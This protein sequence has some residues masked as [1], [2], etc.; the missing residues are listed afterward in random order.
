MKKLILIS[1]ISTIIA[2]SASSQSKQGWTNTE[3]V[4]FY[5]GLL[6]SDSSTKRSVYSVEFLKF[7]VSL[8]RAS[9]YQK[10]GVGTALAEVNVVGNYKP[11]GTILPLY[12]QFIPWMKIRSYAYQPIKSSSKDS[13]GN[14]TLTYDPTKTS[15]EDGAKAFIAITLVG[16]LWGLGE[17]KTLSDGS[18]VRQWNVKYF[19]GRIA[20]IKN[21]RIKSKGTMG[22]SNGF[23]FNVSAEINNYIFF[24]NKEVRY[25]PNIGVRLF[26]GSIL[27][28]Y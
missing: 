21:L 19:N 6:F 26:M 24:E 25:V 10:I 13:F 2:L 15:Y 12:L 23:G 18:Q 9:N 8:G 17:D 3:F 27:E 20:L 28:F 22:V 16:T 11:F 5:G 1:I 4:T 7:S 14:T